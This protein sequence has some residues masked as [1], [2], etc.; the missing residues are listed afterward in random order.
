MQS[1]VTNK[2]ETS[3][4][5]SRG[6]GRSNDNNNRGR[7]GFRGKNNNRG[8]NSRGRGQSSHRGRG[9]HNNNNNNSNLPSLK[10]EN[11]TIQQRLEDEILSIDSEGDLTPVGSVN[12]DSFE[13][14]LQLCSI[15]FYF[16]DFLLIFPESR[17]ATVCSALIVRMISFFIIKYFLHHLSKEIG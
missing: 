15:Y 13:E 6:R 17:K 14:V 10:R 9:S 5:A 16:F 4:G 3:G 2:S 1:E 12:S 11:H 8:Q 7:G